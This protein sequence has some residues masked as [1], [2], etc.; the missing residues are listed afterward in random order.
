MNINGKNINQDSDVYFIADIGANHD[1]SLERAIELINLAKESGADAAKFQHF[2]AD[3]IV[4]DF[5]FKN[6]GSQKSHQSSW[7]KSVYEVYKEASINNEWNDILKKECDK[8][9]ITFF[10]SAYS[11]DLVDEID[12][13]VPAHKI[14]SGDIT[15]HEIVE[16]IANKNKPYLLATGASTINEVEQVVRKCEKINK[17]FCI[18]QCNTN[19][20]ASLE[21][22]KYINLN[23]L[24]TY[25]TLFP[26]KLLGLSDH[27]PGHS[28]VLGAVTLGAM[29][30]EKHFT[31]NCERNGPDHKFAMN[32]SSW[33]EMVNRTQ[34]LKYSLGS[35][36]KVIENNEL[37]TSVLQRRSIRVK[38]S[39]VKNH[40][41]NRS[42]LEIL[43]PCPAD[44]IPPYEI[45][46]VIGTKVCRNVEK[47]DYLKWEDLIL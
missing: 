28:T 46:K 40:I 14:G 29:I 10:T 42:D 44:A 22:F 26:N 19:Y 43:R 2:K 4:S 45:S 36:L 37:E 41:I 35:G 38:E 8:A 25:K 33:A 5:G 6:L 23:V 16:Y 7:K 1:G 17:N 32:P 31:D 39:L 47:G 3:T 13:L 24:N 18:M 27:T 12:H 15:W 11:F 9:G 21:N 34:E 20:T 30:I